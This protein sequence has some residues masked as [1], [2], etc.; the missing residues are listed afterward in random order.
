LETVSL[1]SSQ[2]SSEEQEKALNAAAAREITLELESLNANWF[3]SQKDAVE[4][5][6]RPQPGIDRPYGNLEDTSRDP[7]PLSPPSA[8]F[9][10]RAVSPHPFHEQSF[11]T[12]PGMGH[13]YGPQQPPVPFIQPPRQYSVPPLSPNQSYHN[14]RPANSPLSGT[15]ITERPSSSINNSPNV[16]VGV[17]PG[18]RT[19]PAAA[20]RKPRRM[21]MENL[22]G[23]LSKGL[24]GSPYPGGTPR[25]YSASGVLPS[26]AS[27]IPPSEQQ[28]KPEP[29][30][31]YFDPYFQP[32]T[33]R[34]DPEFG[35]QSRWADGG[36]Q[37]GNFST[38]LE[39]NG[40]R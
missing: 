25:I 7:S 38:D 15:P 19:I 31:N 8:P 27:F 34:T 30:P 28:E 4:E 36:Y 39:D 20:F 13:S 24:P 16:P 11:N 40:L 2:L 33:S 9:A 12:P 18:T 37:T 3:P 22:Q 26:S 21:S 5:R 23:S 29:E 6:G 10:K 32:G 17:G 14:Y 35:G 1:S